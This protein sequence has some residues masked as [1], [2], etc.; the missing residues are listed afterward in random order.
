MITVKRYILV[1]T[2]GECCYTRK[3]THNSITFSFSSRSPGGIPTNLGGMM[4]ALDEML[5]K[6]NL[7]PFGEV[8]V[9]NHPPTPPVPMTLPMV[10]LVP[11]SK[12]E[13]GLNHIATRMLSVN[14]TILSRFLARSN[15]KCFSR[16]RV[17]TSRL[18]TFLPSSPFSL[19]PSYP[20]SVRGSP[21]TLEPEP[22]TPRASQRSLTPPAP[23]SVA[24]RKKRRW[25]QLTGNSPHHQWWVSK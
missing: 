20:A 4:P 6:S 14:N 12:D 22:V 25:K 1:P 10:Y 3:K 5:R 19:R 2:G 8:R 7:I 16:G 24:V 9:D 18:S 23:T 13:V 11:V 21:P 15:I 17:R